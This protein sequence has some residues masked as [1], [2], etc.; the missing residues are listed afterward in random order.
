[1]GTVNA[2]I[3]RAKRIVVKIGSSLIVGEDGTPRA[4]WLQSL[5]ADIARWQGRGCEVLLVSSGAV[6][7]GRGRLG[8]SNPL[9]LEQKQAAAAIGQ[10]LLM[11]A[12]G[13]AFA[14]HDLSIAQALLSLDDTERRRRWLN[15]RATL[16]T[17]LDVGILPVVNENDTVATDEIRYGDNDRLAARVAQMLSADLLVLLSD[18]DGLYT[19]DPRRDPS[20]EHLPLISAFTPTIEAMAGGANAEDGVGSGGM[21]TKL[22]AAKIAHGAGCATLIACGT[23]TAPLEALESGGRAT[24]VQPSM[25]PETARLSWLKG[26]LR[27][28][29]EIIIDA[30]AGRAL[31]EGASLLP[32]G[33]VDVSGQFDR[34]SAIA[35]KSAGGAV[36]AKGITAY[37]AADIR[38]IAGH[39]S[40]DI[41]SIL[42]VA[43]RAA[44][45]HRNDLV[46]DR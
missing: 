13:D 28:E 8:L 11:G 39:R 2:A 25:S 21:V 12:L 7:L 14:G 23:Q 37:S 24:L 26:H 32:V 46:I 44:I 40:E 16:E 10:P 33:V 31:Q 45:V 38:R 20:A 29:G 42:G 17:L 35:I 3:A 15:A 9:R 30:G 19:S 18:I 1:M 22:A 36:L 41:P 5:A 34:G 27:P 6:A 43:R 4:A